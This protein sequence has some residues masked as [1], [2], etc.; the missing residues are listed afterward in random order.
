MNRNL[1][2]ALVLILALAACGSKEPE[3]D[4]QGREI[5]MQ[6][7]FSNFISSWAS[8]DSDDGNR[9]GYDGE[10][11]QVI[12]G[13][14]SYDVWTNPGKLNKN[15]VDVI[16]DIDAYRKAGPLDGSYGVTCGHQDDKNF[17]VLAIS[18]DGYAEIYKYI[19]EV[20]ASIAHSYDNTAINQDG[21]NHI[22]ASCIGNELVLSVNGEELL[23]GTSEELKPGN[24][25]LIAGNY[26][27]AGMEANFDNLVVVKP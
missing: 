12:V 4:A 24:I 1:I 8:A 25:G 11:F 16:I 20:Y 6:D 2:I 13:V 22:T 26:E 23:R 7:D 10:E 21:P 17:H 19:D 5:L 15:E 18:S 14:P 9:V 3:L 27:T